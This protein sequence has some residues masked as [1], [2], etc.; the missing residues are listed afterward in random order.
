MENKLLPVLIKK[1]NKTYYVGVDNYI[2]GNVEIFTFCVMS[3]ENNKMAVE[4][5]ERIVNKFNSA[6]DSPFNYYCEQLSLFYNTTV[7]FDYH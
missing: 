1:P 5:T 4:Q 2:E 7:L 6:V 3:K